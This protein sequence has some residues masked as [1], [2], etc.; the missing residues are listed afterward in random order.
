MNSQICALV[1]DTLYLRY[2]DDNEMKVYTIN[3]TGR[4]MTGDSV[5]YDTVAAV[6]ISLLLKED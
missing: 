4:T 5:A 1:N 6:R 2:K 3:S